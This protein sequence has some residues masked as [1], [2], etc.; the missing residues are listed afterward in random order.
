MLVPVIGLVQ[1]GGQAR[2]DRY[3]YLPQIGLY[4]MI[5]WGLAALVAGWQYRRQILTALAGVVLAALIWQSGVQTSYWRQRESL[6]Q[7]TL[8]VT[9]DTEVAHN[10]LGQD[11]LR[12]GRRDEAIEHFQT[13]LRMRPGFLDA[14][15]NLGVTLLQEGKIDDAIIHFRRVLANNPQL[16]KGHFDMGSALLQK[17]EPNEALPFEIPA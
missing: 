3:T 16:A 15:S 10:A 4:L 6:W 2:A 8:A 9:S 5:S 17:Q 13:A 14:E 11:L 7:H 12:Q 1:V